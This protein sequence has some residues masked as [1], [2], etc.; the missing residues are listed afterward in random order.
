MLVAN[1]EPDLVLLDIQLS[2]IGGIEVA[3]RLLERRPGL[4]I[5]LVS[6]RDHRDYGSLVEL[7]GARGFVSK[8]ELSGAPLEGLLN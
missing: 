4:A 2:G 7:S 1:L 5:V 6:T 8:A 3:S